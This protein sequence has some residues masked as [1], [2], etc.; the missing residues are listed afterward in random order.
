VTRD[1]VEQARRILM[2]RDGLTEAEAFQRIQ[3]D[4]RAGR[5]SMRATAEAIIAGAS[6]SPKP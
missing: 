3:R 1:L 4:S 6:Q 2:E 5:R